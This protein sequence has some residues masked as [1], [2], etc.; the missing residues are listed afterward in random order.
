[1]TFKR[2]HAVSILCAVVFGLSACA[3]GP[4]VA[5]INALT[6]QIVKASFRDESHVKVER[7]TATDET[8]RLCSQADVTGK[9]L[10]EATA[11]RIE[12]ANLQS[13]KWPSDG[14]FLGDWK[15][16]EAIAQSGRG[17]TWTDKAGDVNG[18]NCYNCH[19]ISKEEISHGTLGPSLYNYGKLRGVTDPDSP[20]AKPIVEYTWGKIWNSKAYNA[21][22]NMPRAG[23]SGIL[24]EAQVR[25]IVALLLDPKSPVNK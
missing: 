24:T 23:H 8:N 22:S 1:M 4:S 12:A 14:K 21:C 6:D 3:Q 11:K 19:Q 15:Q 13:I 17:L 2:I 5:E 10:D 9:P 25:H 18:G 16:G 7:L 20:A